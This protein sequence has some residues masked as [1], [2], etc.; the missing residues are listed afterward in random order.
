VRFFT[1]CAALVA[2]LI[3]LLLWADGEEYAA[4][5]ACIAVDGVPVRSLADFVCIR[6]DAVLKGE[7]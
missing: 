2:L 7:L 5:K 6:K 3:C 4:A 1:F